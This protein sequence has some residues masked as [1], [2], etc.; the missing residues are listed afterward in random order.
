MNRAAPF[1]LIPWN[2]DFLRGLTDLALAETNGNIS[3]A[4]FI[5]PHGRPKRYLSLLL[6]QDAAVRRPLIMPV[7]HT[8]SALFSASAGRIQ[9]RPAW[10]AGLLDRIG[11]LLACVRKE[12]LEGADM[13][14]L[15]EARAFFPW[16]ARLA[17]LYE[18]CFS[19]HKTPVDFLHV[20]DQVSPFAAMLL[21]RLGSIFARYS[22]AMRERGW[23]SP[24]HAAGLAAQHVLETG[25]LP[26]GLLPDPSVSPVYIAGFHALSGAERILFRHLWERMNARV[27]LHG[28][29]ALCSSPEKAHW[30]CLPLAEWAK[31]WGTHIALHHTG[32]TVPQPEKPRIRYVSGFDLHSQLAVL[33]EELADITANGREAPNAAPGNK[34]EKGKLPVTADPPPG[35]HGQAF[36]P[37][38]LLADKNPAH[39]AEREEEESFAALEKL[40]DP[41]ADH[42]ADTLVAL[43]DNG[44][45]MPVLHHLPRRDV[46]VSMGYPLAR[47]PVFRL[48][49]TLA[50]LQEGRKKNGYY[51]RDLVEL[52]RHPYLKM[53]RPALS[54]QAGPGPEYPD[55][56]HSGP[57]AGKNGGRTDLRRELHRLE[58]ALRGQDRKYADPRHLAGAMYTPLPAHERPKP[59]TAALLE[60]LF[61]V[62]LDAFEN[63]GRPLDLAGALEGLCAFL[64]AH[65]RHLWKR[66]PIDAECLHRLRQSLIPEL[67]RSE[68]AR[69][70]FAPETLFA[71]LRNL[72]EAE[73]VPFEA[74]PLVGLQV[75]GMLETRLLSFRRVCIVD[76]GEDSL[77]GSPAGD[78]LLP[79]AL[80]REIGLPSLHSREQVAAYTFFRLIFG[81]EEVL[82]LW[83]E[84][85][86]TPSLQDQKKKKSRFIE[87]LLWEEEKKLGRLL[88]A[89]GRD[90]PLTVLESR[91]A[92]LPLQPRA[93][94]VSP[95][96]RALL[97]ALLKKPLS[98]SL[99]DAYLRC[100]ARFYY[101]RLIGLA[102]ADEVH[103]GDDPLAVGNL[104]H[105]VLRQ[106]YAPL[107]E[108]ALPG[109]DAL[110]EELRDDLLALYYSSSSFAALMRSLPADS[111]AML[112]EAGKKRLTD[113]L[114]RQPPTRVMAVETPFTVTFTQGGGRWSLTGTADRIDQRCDPE[115]AASPFAGTQGL[116][117][118]DYKTGR[119]PLT[120]FSL[121]ENEGLW[122]RM[123]SWAPG[124]AGEENSPSILAELAGLLESVQLPLYLLLRELAVSSGKAGGRG[125]SPPALDAAFVALAQGGEEIPLFAPALGL[126]ERRKII[127]NRIPDLVF[128]L[129]SHMSAC[130]RLAPHP[131]K[132]CDWC[133]CSKL[134]MLPS[135]F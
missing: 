11:L 34:P 30:S 9:S 62:T 96:V 108:R 118:L 47:S 89:Q 70:S 44:L 121:W 84:G 110:A 53:L 1:T 24:G 39:E 67:G 3:R 60:K 77:P 25:E 126:A 57:D 33:Q 32:K 112:V 7:M 49:D 99:F 129:I 117:I 36:L 87:E 2:T 91:A 78:P 114:K 29:A 119:V 102:P 133:S 93:I 13:P 125:E 42:R 135:A 98:A 46:N 90:G 22:T 100:P 83:Q 103:E 88:A 105:D 55:S 31:D 17:A 61:S 127:E 40:A 116:I 131:G 28:D 74:V 43:P 51:W 15:T 48:L 27:V 18:E 106:G 82:L 130:T 69:E 10:N 6:R 111:A 86:D 76:A 59:E 65:G 52:I 79:E 81:A 23:T 95:P 68:L 120:A 80:R 134:C 14:F 37:I 113:Y 56:E 20:E 58:Q 122:R 132:H 54:D 41:A 115:G 75:M 35:N 123:A 19:Q 101:E 124:A 4:V 107:L 63:P 5:F 71:L 21:S 45:L 72:M 128:F 50:R 66:F 64:L 104:F 38:D 97:D 94:T 8:V 85:G 109:G 26:D 73:R 16:G 12:A 92:P